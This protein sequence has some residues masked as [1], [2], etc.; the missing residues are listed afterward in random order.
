M[1]RPA[2]PV[3]VTESPE[4]NEKAKTML[5]EKSAPV[6]RGCGLAAVLT[7]LLAAPSYAYIDPGSGS[8]IF[9]LAIAAIAGAIYTIKLSWSRLR[10]ILSSLIFF[11]RRR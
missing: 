3:P 8:Y 6:L 5:G 9:Q 7:A 4:L 10:P 11:W 1:V 2:P